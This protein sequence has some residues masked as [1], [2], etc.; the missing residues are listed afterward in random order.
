M[1]YIER[2]ST[3][4][5]F[6]IAK[7]FP[8]A[9]ITGPRQSG[10]TTL[11]RKAFPDLPYINLEAPDK[12]EYAESD[13]RGFLDTIQSG[14]VLDEIQRAPDILSY[15]QE[16]VDRKMPGCR[17]VLTGSQ[18]LGLAATISQS[19]AGRA[20]FLHLP[21]FSLSEIYGKRTSLPLD[22]VL[23]RG[24]Y[25]PV[26]DRNIDPLD[27]YAAYVQS[28][29]ERDVR[30][31]V[32][33]HDLSDFQR[34]MRLCA[35]RTG[36]LLNLSAMGQECGVS[37]TTIKAWLSVLEAGYVVFR[38]QPHF[39]N[40]GKRLIKMP[41][42]YFLDTGLA[43]YLLSIHAES[44][45]AAHPLRGALFENLVVGEFLKRR[46]NAGLQSNLYFWRDRT[47]NE[48]DLLLDK[49]GMLVPAE[50]K[51]GM[52]FQEEWTAP[53]HRWT[54]LAGKGGIAPHCIYGGDET[55]AGSSVNLFSWRDSG[56][57]D[58]AV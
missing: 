44:H 52:T 8:I 53:A 20:G 46:Y 32:R 12:R 27:F 55:R 15:L 42:L 30:Q 57:T 24:L 37:H 6:R 13:P 16:L 35:S 34:F 51:A 19:L 4:T 28:Y 33:V 22:T 43:A 29:L 21:P 40:Y 47:G 5:L 25:P 26:H 54:K 58:A 50:I 39:E 9:V 3:E 7:S 49:G 1:S 41:K 38:L 10:K 48:V 56:F 18:Q 2:C 45:L 36:Q 11:A 14:A 17:F 23:F 31:L